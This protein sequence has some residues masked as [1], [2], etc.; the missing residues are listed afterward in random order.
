M[1]VLPDALLSML[2]SI[3]VEAALHR[4]G[5]LV[6][7]EIR[8]VSPLAQAACG[9]LTA[10]EAPVVQF[11]ALADVTRMRLDANQFNECVAAKRMREAP[12]I[13]LVE[14]HQRRLEGEAAIHAEVQRDLQRLHRIVAAIRVA[15]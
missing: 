3:A 9:A 2:V 8:F 14:P 7:C 5:D 10:T 15:R 4:L 12:R 1:L 13:G 11:R 6:A